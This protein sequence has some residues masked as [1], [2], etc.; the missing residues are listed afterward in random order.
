MNNFFK[1]IRYFAEAIIVKLS[2]KFFTILG[3][4]KASD[5]GSFLARMVG[6]IHA[7]HKLAMQN[8]GKALP[9]LG[10][11]E[12]DQI[13]ENMWDNLGRVVGEY[14]HIVKA[15][16]A[17]LMEK[18]V[19]ID[20]ETRANLDFLKQ[21]KKGGIFFSGHLGNWEIGPKIFM[22][23][24]FEVSTVYRP[25]NNPYV[26]KM[27][28]SIR[29]SKLI[30]KGTQGSRQIIEALKKGEYIL[31]MADQKISEGEPIKFFHEMAV[32]AT[33]IARIAIK[34][35]VPLIPVRSIRLEHFFKFMAKIER[36]LVFQKTNDINKDV[37]DFT[38]L[39]NCKLEDWIT[40]YPEQWFWVH[41]RWKK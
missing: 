18:Y 17:E 29:G 34:Y 16:P 31:I 32:T 27:T 7:T 33:A 30:P 26:E 22:H 3:P 6:K 15:T 8:L 5:L 19:I 36:P 9:N 40:E 37:A 11:K 35:D 25:L 24:G 12:K 10:A 2:L 14:V 21:N 38:R 1:K 13:L 39:I 41:D 4:Q 28:A 23:E 20:R